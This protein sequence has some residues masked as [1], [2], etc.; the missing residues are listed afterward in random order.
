MEHNIRTERAPYPLAALDLTVT[1]ATGKQISIAADFRSEI[2]QD[3]SPLTRILV[4]PVSY[5]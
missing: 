3:L 1:F 2:S 5:R 4:R